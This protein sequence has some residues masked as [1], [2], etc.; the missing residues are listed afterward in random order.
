MWHVNRNITPS[1]NINEAEK[2][3][4]GDFRF[5]NGKWI[6][7]NRKLDNMW[8]VS[9][10]DNHK[11]IAINS[12]VELTE[13]KKILLDTAKGGRLILVQLVHNYNYFAKEANGAREAYYK[14]AYYKYVGLAENEHMQGQ[15]YECYAKNA[16]QYLEPDYDESEVNPFAI[17][18][19]EYRDKARRCSDR[20]ADYR[21]QAD[22]YMGLYEEAVRNAKK[23]DDE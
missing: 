20:E 2:G 21:R 5:N 10:Q 6:L 17:E 1:E 13:G 22:Y 23:Y 19:K 4:V 15:I 12:F 11:Q 3:P 18:A 8:D 9:E 16:E 7:I 14:E